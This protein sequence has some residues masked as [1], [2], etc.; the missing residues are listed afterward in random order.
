MKVQLAAGGRKNLISVA[1]IVLIALGVW[2]GWTRPLG[3]VLR[4]AEMDSPVDATLIRSIPV[5]Q[6]DGSVAYESQVIR[7]Q[8]DPGSEAAL[9]LAGAMEE[10][11]VRGRLRLP[12]ERVTV[13]ATG[14]DSLSV[15]FSSEGKTRDLVLLSGSG[16]QAS[17]FI[18]GPVVRLCSAA[19]EVDLLRLGPQTLC[20]RSA[21]GHQCQIGFP[22]LLVEAAGV[23]VQLMHG[24]QHGVYGGFAHGGGSR[25]VSVYEH[26]L[27]S[28]FPETG[29]EPVN[30]FIIPI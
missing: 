28:F 6:A 29:T 27:D 30:A 15:T 21:G 10:V 17:P 9:A 4:A 26:R 25:V 16:A 2:M 8:A 7:L 12:F 23:A 19:G 24:W 14:Q 11:R 20:H 1:A 5:P 18:D 13:Y 3:E 22:A